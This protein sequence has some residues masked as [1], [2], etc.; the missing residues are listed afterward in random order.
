MWKGLL[1]AF[2]LF[3]MLMVFGWFVN[4]SISNELE[5]QVNLE[6]ETIDTL[7]NLEE[8]YINVIE[9]VIITVISLSMALLALY[10]SHKYG[11]DDND[12]NSIDTDNVPFESDKS[13]VEDA[14]DILKRRFANGE[15]DIYEYT[16]RMSRL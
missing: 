10:A 1:L 13:V 3:I 12:Y 4:E 16:E 8:N 14:V 9:L 5:S 11:T 15:I 7:N 6:Q 2:G